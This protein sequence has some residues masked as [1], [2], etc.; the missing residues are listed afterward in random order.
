PDDLGNS[1]AVIAD[2]MRQTGR[3][4]KSIA[5]G[6]SILVFTDC[7]GDLALQDIS[8]FVALMFSEFRKTEVTTAWLDSYQRGLKQGLGA[9]RDE[10]LSLSS[11][12]VGID[13]AEAI[14]NRPLAAAHDHLV[15][16]FFV[17]E[18]GGDV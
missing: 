6:K 17:T 1:L 5:F 11:F 9:K 3:E 10:E 12:G 13:S 15:A 4:E 14:K 16:A 2:A 18:E 8:D 7:Q